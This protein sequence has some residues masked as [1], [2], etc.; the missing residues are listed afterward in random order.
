MTF[1]QIGI[2]GIA[3]RLSSGSRAS[4][5]TTAG[6]ITTGAAPSNLVAMPIVRSVN[7]GLSTGEANGTTRATTWELSLPALFKNELEF[8]IPWQ[9]TDAGFMALQTAFF[10]RTSI[11]LAVLDGDKATIGSQ[12]IWADYMVADFPR[13]E[14]ED[15]EMLSK[16]KLKPTVSAHG[17]EW[18]QVNT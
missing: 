17:P 18:V 8:E 2:N 7:L 12:G 13:E 11:A 4:W 16:V 5:G 9:P 14:P 10:G 1:I 3:Y 15:K 6:G